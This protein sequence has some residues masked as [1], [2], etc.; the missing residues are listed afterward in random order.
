MLRSREKIMECFRTF[1]TKS[2]QIV[3][4]Q[5]ELCVWLILAFA[6]ENPVAATQN[7]IFAFFVPELHF[8]NKTYF[9]NRHQP[10][11]DPLFSFCMWDCGD[12]A[13]YSWKT[14]HSMLLNGDCDTLF[15]SVTVQEQKVSSSPTVIFSDIRCCPLIRMK[16]CMHRITT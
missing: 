1:F 13:V 2:N 4:L 7:E 12:H 8:G 9:L 14:D 6:T 16:A 15:V 11:K 5:V 10:E 3:D